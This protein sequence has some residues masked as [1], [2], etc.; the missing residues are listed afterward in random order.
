MSF[1]SALQPRPPPHTRVLRCFPHIHLFVA[2]FHNINICHHKL[3]FCFW[4]CASR[5]YARQITSQWIA[6]CY[7]HSGW[8]CVSQS[9][10]KKQ[11]WREVFTTEGLTETSPAKTTDGLIVLTLWNKLWTIVFE[12]HNHKRLVLLWEFEPFGPIISGKSCAVKLFYPHS[13]GD[14]SQLSTDRTAVDLFWFQSTTD[15]E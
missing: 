14:V 3:I 12:H 11:R 5:S 7:I 10:G 9:T 4:S 13:K 1:Y 2:V 8:D 15:Q 6:R